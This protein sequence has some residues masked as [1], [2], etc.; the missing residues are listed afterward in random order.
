MITLLGLKKYIIYNQFII[1]QW[2]LEFWT[3]FC[4]GLSTTIR[5]KHRITFQSKHINTVTKLFETNVRNSILTFVD[6]ISN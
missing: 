5:M 2:I 3:F 6:L 1:F 4:G